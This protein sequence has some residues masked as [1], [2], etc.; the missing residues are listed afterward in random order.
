[1]LADDRSFLDRLTQVE[2]EPFE[3]WNFSFLHGRMV[4]EPLPWNYESL[5]QQA[6]PHAQSLLDMDTGGGEKLA[7]WQPLPPYT[8]ATEGYAPNIPVARTRL[9]PLGVPVLEVESTGALPLPSD[10]FA[11]ASGGGGKGWRPDRGCFP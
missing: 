8:V 1:L 7:G 10:A 5:V 2:Q 9:E 3:G 6:L 4:A 11:S